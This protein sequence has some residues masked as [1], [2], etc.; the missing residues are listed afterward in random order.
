MR[1]IHT[2]LFPRSAEVLYLSRTCP[3]G[4]GL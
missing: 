2:E 3:A 4:F 1:D